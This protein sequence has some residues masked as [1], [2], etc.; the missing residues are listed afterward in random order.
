MDLS[1]MRLIPTEVGHF[2]H[3]Y[4]SPLEEARDDLAANLSYVAQSLEKFWLGLGTA[5]NCKQAFIQCMTLKAWMHNK[6]TIHTLMCDKLA[7][8]E[9]EILN[10]L[11]VDPNLEAQQLSQMQ[12]VLF[13]L[14]HLSDTITFETQ[15]LDLMLAH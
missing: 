13:M 4:Q 3:P 6:P 2:H 1:N 15:I 7:S 8:L 5:Q 12:H 10:T 11:D 14:R 9:E